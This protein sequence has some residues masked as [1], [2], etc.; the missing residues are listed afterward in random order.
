M[1]DTG[2]AGDAYERYL[3][4][5]S[6]RVARDSIDW[7]FRRRSRDGWESVAA[8]RR[9]CRKPARAAPVTEGGRVN[10]TA[11]CPLNVCSRSATAGCVLTLVWSSRFDAWLRDLADQR[12]RARILASRARLGNFG[13]CEPVGEGVSEMR[14]DFGPG[15]RIY[16]VRQGTITYLLLLGGDKS[17]QDRDIEL[18]K[19]MAR[20]LKEE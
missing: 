19:A 15:Y 10:G 11:N 12:A 14:I 16:F 6:R 20:E 2:A 3:G 8:S 13:D 4:R 17:T 5:R 7:Q 9:S 18:A 1:Q